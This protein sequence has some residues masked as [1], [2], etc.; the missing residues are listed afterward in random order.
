MRA[1]ESDLRACRALL[2]GGSRS[3]HAASLLL[4]ARVHQPAGA[5]YAFCRLADDEIDNAIDGDA[6]P[7][8]GQHGNAAA[9]LG[10]LR[11]RLDRVYAG[12]PRNH[13]VD[14]AMASVVEHHAVP[15]ALPEALLEGFA[16]DAEGRT[17]ETLSDVRAYAA[18]VAGAVGAM[19]TVLMGCREPRTVARACDLGVAMQLSN[20]ARDVGEDARVGRLYL[21]REWLRAEGLDPDA[22]L[23]APEFNDVIARAVNRLVAEADILYRRAEAGIAEL[24]LVCRPGIGA[25]RLLYAEI[26]HEVLRQGGNSIAGRAVVPGRRKLALVAR[27]LA[28]SLARIAPDEAPALPETRFLVE[29]VAAEPAPVLAAEPGGSESFVRVCEMF[30]RLDARD[31]AAGIM[32]AARAAA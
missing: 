31:H 12:R 7:G 18:R 17:Y 32:R 21:P 5:L 10:R 14:R 30:V 16:W 2:R 27:S 8:S 9:A 6:V 28:R 24:P 23:A 13:P 29:A 11:E 20:I 26:G 1:N 19:M 15:R 3:F 4:P 25:A 22:W